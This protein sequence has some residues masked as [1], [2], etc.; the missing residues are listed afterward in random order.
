VR[1]AEAMMEVLYARCA[2]LDVHKE[3]V[4]ACVLTPSAGAEPNKQIGEFGTTTTELRRLRDWLRESGVTH[5]AMESTGVYWKPVFNIL[6]STCQLIVVNA[7]HIKQVPGRK[8][9]KADCAWI[10]SLLRHGLLQ[11]SF[12]PE[13]EVR[14]LRDLCRTRTT[15]VRE[16]VQVGN[17][18]RKILEDA[19]IKLDSVASDALGVS[20]REMILALVRGNDDPAAL[21]ELARGRL[22]AKLPELERALEGQVTAH[23][24]FLLREMMRQLAFLEGQVERFERQIGRCMRPFE[25]A[26]ELLITMPGVDRTAACA[27]IAEIGADMSRFPSSRHLASWA[28]LCPGNN[29]SAGK[30]RSGKSHRGNRWIRGLMTEIAWAASRTKN[31]YSA[32]QYRRLT[33]HRGKKRALVA[34]ANSLLQAAWHMLSQ[35]QGYIE[36]GAQYLDSLH[37]K[38]TERALIRRLEKLGHK[39]ILEPVA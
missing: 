31:S 6:E 20:G 10:A 9:D 24:R 34:V 12:V 7:R 2:G 14:Q 39:V 21:A 11:A 1:L 26:A 15:L 13:A 23:H 35:R 37:Q 27:L 32:T 17:R 19:N 5:A 36:L 22:R 8:T 38:E 33:G 16:C 3:T 18:L 29:E 30:R 25:W 4:A 28:G